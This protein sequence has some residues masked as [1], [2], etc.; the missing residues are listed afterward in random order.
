MDTGSL[1]NTLAILDVGHGNS[2]VLIDTAGVAVIDSGP[3][4]ALLEFLEQQRITCVDLVL[5][6][7]ADEDHIGA[8]AQLLGCGRFRVGWVALNS[9][10]TKG[11]A[12]WDDLLYEL[13]K[14]HSAGGTRFDV[15]LVQTAGHVFDQGRV[16]IEV[17]G[18]SRY[19]AGKGPG[20]TDREG[21]RIATNSISAAIRLSLDSEPLA[22]FLGDM[23]QV[24][25]DDLLARCPNTRSRLLLFPHHGG[26]PGTAGTQD[27]VGRLLNAVRPSTIVFS[28]GRGMHATPN[29]DV[30]AAIRQVL[31]DAA[32]L[33]TQLSEHCAEALPPEEGRHLADAFARGRE[34]RICCAGTVL[35]RLTSPPQLLPTCE[36]H[37]AFLDSAAP[38]AL[39]RR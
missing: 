17:L 11:S 35:L 28:I 5:I 25:L 1:Q 33:C 15:S 4:T 36:A 32:I 21:R 20:A 16:H 3:G 39:C 12:A 22:L 37:V 27:F 30:M 9:D 38:S 14:A 13:D 19:L 26:R 24:G 8:L 10:A 7:H 6:S 18:P 29:P 2:A 31:P 23:D 34:K